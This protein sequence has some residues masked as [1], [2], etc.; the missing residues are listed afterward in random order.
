MKNFV[1]EILRDKNGDF[2]IR[3]CVIAILVVIII[4]SWIAQ[5]FFRKDVP[6]FM[7]YSFVSLIAAGC[8]GYSLERR[9]AVETEFKN[10]KIEN[11]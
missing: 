5:Q 7:F 1:L 9:S 4:V 11:V 2:S 10:E 3:E 8:F 6:E